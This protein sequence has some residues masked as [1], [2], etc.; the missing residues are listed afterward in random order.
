MNPGNRGPSREEPNRFLGF[1]VGTGRPGR[2]GRDGRD[3]EEPQRFMGM[4]VDWLGS[5]DLGRISWLAHPV[6]EYR[7]WAQRRPPGPHGT[8]EIDP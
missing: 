2:D 7:R 8:D 6:R 1:P 3:G 5:A 4:P